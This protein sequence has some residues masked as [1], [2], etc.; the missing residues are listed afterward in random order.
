MNWEKEIKCNAC[1]ISNNTG[2]E[3]MLDYIYHLILKSLWNR[4]LAKISQSVVMDVIYI[5]DLTYVLMCYWI[6]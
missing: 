6:H 5:E 4:V 3:L 2:A 1:H